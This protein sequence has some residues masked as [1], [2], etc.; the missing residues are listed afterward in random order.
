MILN[1]KMDIDE[2]L[3]DILTISVSGILGTISIGGYC[4][5]LTNFVQ[6]LCPISGIDTNQILINSIPDIELNELMDMSW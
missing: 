6:S 2:M 3:L 4:L 1:S 5:V